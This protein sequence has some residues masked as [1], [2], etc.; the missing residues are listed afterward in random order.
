MK[1]TISKLYSVIKKSH[2]LNNPNIEEINFKIR[3]HDSVIGK[4]IH[5]EI[6]FNIV[7]KN[8]DLLCYQNYY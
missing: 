5:N 8:K 6:T 2:L 3:L 7:T 4:D 1:K